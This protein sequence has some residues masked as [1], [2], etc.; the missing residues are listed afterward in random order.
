MFQAATTALQVSTAK[1]TSDHFGRNNRVSL[2]IISI[3]IIGIIVV[4]VIIA[5]GSTLELLVVAGCDP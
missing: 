3:I 5:A 2:E 1:S 4:I